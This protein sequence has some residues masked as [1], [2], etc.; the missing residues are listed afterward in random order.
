MKERFPLEIPWCYEIK[1][2][3]FHFDKKSFKYSGNATLLNTWEPQ[4]RIEAQGW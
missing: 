3:R 4:A 1:T 2:E